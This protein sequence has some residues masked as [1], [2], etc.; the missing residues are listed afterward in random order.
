MLNPEGDTGVYLEYAHAR[1]SSVL[2]KAESAYGVKAEALI[3]AGHTTL[4]ISEPSEIDL[5]IEILRF[6][7]ITGRVMRDLRPNALCEL[8]YRICTRFSTFI[9]PG[10]CR[11]L[12][13]AAMQSR[14]L[15]CYIAKLH[16]AQLMV[17]V[18]LKPIDRI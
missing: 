18:G 14:V 1:M 2:R 9:S 13:T 16:V 12:G 11:V 5:A 10:G 6:P 15:L 7:S 4:N 3:A 8:L 17:L